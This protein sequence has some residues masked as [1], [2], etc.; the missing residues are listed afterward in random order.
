[1]NIDIIVNI[2]TIVNILAIIVAPIVALMVSKWLQ[3]RD[4]KRRDKL[5]IF[6]ALMISRENWSAESVR[7]LNILD[8][9]FSDD[10]DVRRKWREYYDKLC[11]D[12]PTESDLVKIKTAQEKL[13]ETM[14]DSLGYKDSVTWDIIQHPY[15]PRGM[16]EAMN[17]Q[18]D[19]QN[20]QIEI[21]KAV[22][23]GIKSKGGS[24]EKDDVNKN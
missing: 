13:L 9:T 20:K 14:A 1:M 10:K 24:I 12:N 7:A 4:E 2:D 6:K 19:L 3:N 18:F 5:E 16:R 22:Y 23:E 11:V 8:I 15:I 17:R 21:M